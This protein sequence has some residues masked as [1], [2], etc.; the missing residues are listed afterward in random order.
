MRECGLRGQVLI[1]DHQQLRPNT[2][3]Y[4][5]SKQFQ[6]DV[7]LFER[8]IRNGA[9]HV[10]LTHQRRMRPQVSQPPKPLG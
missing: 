5:L 8:L 6:L 2:A 10:S 9:A 4:R 3:V 1:G 7:S